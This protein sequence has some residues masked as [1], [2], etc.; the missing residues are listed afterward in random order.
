MFELALAR[1]TTS[2]AEDALNQ[3]VASTTSSTLPLL[4]THSWFCCLTLAVAYAKA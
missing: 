3:T 2:H 1:I 4:R